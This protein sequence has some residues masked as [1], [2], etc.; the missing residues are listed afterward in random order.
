[1][2][3]K[4]L[5][6]QNKKFRLEDLKIFVPSDVT[7][8]KSWTLIYFLMEMMTSFDWS[9]Q[10][11]RLVKR[12][13]VRGFW[14]CLL[15]GWLASWYNWQFLFS[16]PH[17]FIH[18]LF[19]HVIRSLT[20]LMWRHWNNEQA[21][22]EA[23]TTIKNCWLQTEQW[24]ILRWNVKVNCR[25]SYFIVVVDLVWTKKDFCV[26]FAFFFFKKQ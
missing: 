11:L 24:Q 25:V 22:R 7:A 26:R 6:S 23:F 9:N 4:H 12:L 5:K 1:M 19:W 20:L 3:Q 2:E 15:R 8:E 21:L 14:F 10:R 13:N 16:Q 17:Q 18:F